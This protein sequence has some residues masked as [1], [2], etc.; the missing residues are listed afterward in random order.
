MSIAF[1]YPRKGDLVIII[2][3]WFLA[4]GKIGGTPSSSFLHFIW[5]PVNLTVPN[6]RLLLG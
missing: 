4:R 6:G 5:K 3:F 1:K 2:H